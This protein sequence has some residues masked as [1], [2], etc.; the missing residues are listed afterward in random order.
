MTAA[1]HSDFARDFSAST[2]RA[3]LK[4]GIVVIGIC[5]IP[6]MSH[7]TYANASRGYNMDDNGTHRVR[8]YAEVRA[9]V[10]V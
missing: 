3:L 8:S 7:P 6:D 4:R 1:K 9:M 10:E 2:R 5:A